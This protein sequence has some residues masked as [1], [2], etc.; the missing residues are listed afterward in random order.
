MEAGLPAFFIID[1]M[2]KI[3][4]I[5]ND[6]A[7][8]LS[9][10]VVQV[11]MYGTDRRVL[12]VTVDTLAGGG[13]S[14]GDCRLLSRNF[15]TA[16]DVEDIIAGRY[17]LEVNSAGLERQLYKISDYKK[18]VGRLVK[19]KLHN[20][21]LDKKIYEGIIEA[22]QEDG[23]ASK[24]VVKQDDLLCAIDFNNV[25][26]GRLVITDEMFKLMLKR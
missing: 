4:K 6:V 21:F 5:L 16:L 18:F 1:R 13:I 8:S 12:E 25:K 17:Y 2:E 11:K 15:S 9:F 20:A 26:S 14:I 19:I 7:E 22:V 24:V 3:S 10:E 23:D